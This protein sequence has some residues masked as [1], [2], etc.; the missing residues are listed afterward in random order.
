MFDLRP[1]ERVEYLVLIDREH[2]QHDLLIPFA[3]YNPYVHVTR[4]TEPIN[5]V[6]KRFLRTKT[7]RAE[8]AKNGSFFLA[9]ALR[10]IPEAAWLR[11]GIRPLGGP[12]A[13]QRCCVAEDPDFARVFA[14]PARR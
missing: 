7:G 9:D 12:D 11:E 1:G 14:S 4:L 2:T 6:I 5:A 10:V 8:V 13:Q 3:V